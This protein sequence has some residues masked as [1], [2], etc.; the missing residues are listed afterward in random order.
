[1]SNINQ[2]EEFL[3]KA[4]QLDRAT[5][6]YLTFFFSFFSMEFYN[7]IKISGNTLP[8]FLRRNFS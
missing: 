6:I 7:Y 4:I 8:S 2:T 5:L 1:M 3:I